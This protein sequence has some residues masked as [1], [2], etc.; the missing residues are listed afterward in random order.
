MT[1]IGNRTCQGVFSW[2]RPRERRVRIPGLQCDSRTGRR[3][4]SY[5]P[6]RIAKTLSFMTADGPVLIIAAG[7]ARIDNQKFK[8][9]FSC[10][11]KFLTPEEVEQATG[12]AVGGVCPFALASPV[13][14]FVDQS[15][16]RFDT[17]FPAC[18]SANSAIELHP[19]EFF[20]LCPG[21]Q[22][23]DVCKLPD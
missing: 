5:D 23:T 2:P 12:H 22:W 1:P 15:V 7:D 16:K 9:Q 14:V 3:G 8:A 10:K 11:A 21:A 18:G 17:V 4:T 13:P 20:A 19:E 6:A